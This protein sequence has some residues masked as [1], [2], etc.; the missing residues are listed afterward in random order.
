M[1]RIPRDVLLRAFPGQPRLVAAMEDFFT[2]AAAEVERL[3]AAKETAEAAAGGVAGALDQLSDKQ[4]ASDN[5]TAITELPVDPGA[6]EQISPGIF[7]VRPIDAEDRLS[8]LTRDLADTRYLGA[9]DPSLMPD[10]DY[11]DIVVS[12]SGAAV[13]FDP[14]VVTPFSRTLLDD[15]SAAAWGATLGLASL[16]YKASINDADWSGADLAI[17]NGGT[18]ASSAPAAR[19]NLGAEGAISAGTTAQYWRGDKSWQTLDKTVVGLANVDNITD[20]AKVVLSASKLTTARTVAATGDV[21]WSGSFDGSAN[22]SVTATLATV[23]SNTGTYGGIKTS[24]QLSLDGKGRVTGASAITIQP[25]YS[26]IDAVPTSRFLGRV[27]AGTGFAEALTAAQAKTL[28]AIAYADVSGLGT[29]AQKNTG[30]SGNT[31]PL[32]DGANTWSAQQTFSANPSLIGGGLAF[33]ATQVPSADANTLDDYK[34]GTF[35]PSLTFAN[36][37][38]GMT[39]AFQTG[40]YTKIGRLVYFRVNIVLTAKGSSTG[41]ARVAGL[42][43]T[44]AASISAPVSVALFAVS[45]LNAPSARVTVNAATVALQNFTGTDSV[46]M[47][48]ANFTNTSTINLSGCYEVA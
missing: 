34:E 13:N 35:T 4:A 40:S 38:V 45:A 43:F 42:P 17:T 48:E 12:S 32:L 24:A 41:V 19:T 20:S 44:S 3:T 33:P 18:G 21:S 46:N 14:S 36:A 29:A 7:S 39:Y 25:D 28:L 27:T 22:F 9:A 1:S 37:S 30:S 31:V 10:G 26:N 23:N 6:I 15:S 5:L 2:E 16:A 8:L 47:T 11:G